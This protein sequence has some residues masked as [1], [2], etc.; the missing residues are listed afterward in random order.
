MNRPKYNNF[1]GVPLGGIGCGKIELCPD[2]AFRH[3]T[4]HNKVDMPLT[5]IHNPFKPMPNFPV[6]DMD[7]CPE[8]HP[9][10][11][12]SCFFGAFVE[13]TGAVVLKEQEPGLSATL[14][15]DSIE[16]VGEV[17]SADLVYPAM[18]GVKLSLAAF[19]SLILNEPEAAQNRDSCVPGVSFTFKIENIL[20][21][22][23]QNPSAT[24]PG[25]TAHKRPPGRM[26][27]PSTRRRSTASEVH[28]WALWIRSSNI[29][30]SRFW[31]MG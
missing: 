18:D 7:T 4:I 28:R 8:M 25:S 20:C 5:D 3:L 27:S 15:R 21:P 26:R 2:G 1:S 12:E 14:P 13:G 24:K 17:P 31:S 16:F 10:G 9:A 22:T 19:S 30:P 11:L 29:R 6:V 23:T